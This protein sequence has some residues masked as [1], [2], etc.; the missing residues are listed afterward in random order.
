MREHRPSLSTERKSSRMTQT[1][2][3]N[4]VRALVSVRL[5]SFIETPHDEALAGVIES[6]IGA[7]S[8]AFV[9]GSQALA[10]GIDLAWRS[11]SQ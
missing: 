2:S 9:S 6:H 10:I 8:L 5:R 3:T 11:P 7:E 1:I 4:T